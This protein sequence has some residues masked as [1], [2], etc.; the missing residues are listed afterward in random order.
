MRRPG[1]FRPVLPLA[2]PAPAE[3]AMRFTLGMP[4]M[5]R[6]AAR[7]QPVGLLGQKGQGLVL[8]GAGGDAREDAA[9]RLLDCKIES[10]RGR[11]GQ[12]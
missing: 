5:P 4:A 8:G 11:Q 7:E 6:G 12:R 3:Q 2:A 1:Q 9:D 10:V